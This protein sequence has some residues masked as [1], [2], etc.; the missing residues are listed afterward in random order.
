MRYNIVSPLPGS[1]LE[2]RVEEGQTIKTG[3][4]VVVLEAMKMEND[5]PADFAGSVTNIS[6]SQGQT[7]QMGDV[8][9]EIE[10][11]DS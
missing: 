4:I 11:Y 5:I 8:L 7:V 9:M 10:A 2:V 3:D 6:V 1:V